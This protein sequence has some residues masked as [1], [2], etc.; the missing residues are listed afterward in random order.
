MFGY[1]T[2]EIEECMFF[3]IVFA[4]RFNVRMVELRRVGV[5]FWLRSDFK[6]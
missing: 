4:Y 1:V 6:I 5:L 3:I 2:D